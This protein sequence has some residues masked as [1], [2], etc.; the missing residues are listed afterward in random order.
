MDVPNSDPGRPPTP[1][2]TFTAPPRAA[3]TLRVHAAPAGVH[4]A[5]DGRTYELTGDQARC[6]ARLL[7]R[8]AEGLGS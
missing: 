3:A 2:P 1:R 8:A 6:C 5:I 4:I 7:E